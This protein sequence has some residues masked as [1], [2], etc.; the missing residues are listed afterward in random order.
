MSEFMV[1]DHRRLEQMLHRLQ[2]LVFEADWR[3]AE[4]FALFI[5][6]GLEKHILM[7]EQVLFPLLAARISF[8]REKE[9]GAFQHEHQQILGLISTIRERLTQVL[10][11]SAPA[12]T[13]AAVV[14]ALHDFLRKFSHHRDKEEKYVYATTDLLLSKEEVDRM[15][16][17]CQ[18]VAQHH[19]E[20]TTSPVPIFDQ[21]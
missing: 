2:E 6:T 11:S 9:L 18:T 20:Q 8:F 16:R 5:A 10:Q 3:R 14:K 17:Q 7:E 4:Q 12:E 15:V 19:G 13:E 21:R 1:S